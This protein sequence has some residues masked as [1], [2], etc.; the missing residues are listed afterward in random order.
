VPVAGELS[1]DIYN[2][3]GQHLK[4]LASG[5]VTAGDYQAVWD[6]TDNLGRTVSSGTYTYRLRFADRVYSKKMLLIK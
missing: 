6:G 1:L 2:M 3:R 4:S 5:N